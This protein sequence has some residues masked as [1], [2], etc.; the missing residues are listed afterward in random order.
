[1]I[2][3]AY[4]SPQSFWE[5]GGRFEAYGIN[6]L[7]LGSGRIDADVIATARAQGASVY[8]EFAT[9]R[10][11]YLLEK[12]PD[13]APVGRDGLPIPK[14]PRFLGACPSCPRLLL[15][16]RAGL[17]RLVREQ[18]VAGVWLDYLHFHCD[19]ELPDPPL[20]D[21]C[22]C[23]R[24]VR[25][26]VTDTGLGDAGHQITGHQ[27]TGHQ[28]TG[29]QIAGRTTA[30]RASW[31]LA[32]V[33]DAWTEWKCDVMA[34]FAAEARRVVDEERPGTKLGVYSAPWTDDEYGGGLRRILGEDI[35]RLHAVVDVFSPMLYQV[36][37]GRPAEWVETYTRWMVGRVGGLNARR[38]RRVEVWPIV[39]A[40]GATAP[41]L[42]TV[43]RGALSGGA[44]GVMFYALPHVV[45]DGGKLGAVRR[46][47]SPSANNG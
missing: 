9:F 36:K 10:G 15:E 19:F 32:E 14:T 1:M 31:I 8:A 7:F 40:E 37:C 28:I 12:Y 17:R 25:R 13:V 44:T 34:G 24:C 45:A 22:F 42:E 5:G 16:K 41:E 6:A 18:P 11:D 43:L 23:D 47:Y 2:Y 26:F 39:E 30:E 4:S 46:V 27:I 35:D 21:S 38:G 20:D 29:H 3:G 33:G